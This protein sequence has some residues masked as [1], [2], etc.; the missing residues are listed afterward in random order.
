MRAKVA[1]TAVFCVLSFLAL[2]ANA[3]DSRPIKHFRG[4]GAIANK[5]GYEINK[6][7]V[8]IISGNPNGT[9]LRLAYDMSAVLDSD[10]LRVLPI[11]GAGGGGNIKDVRFLKGIDLG[12]TQSVLLNRYKRTN[13]IGPIDDKLVYIAKLNNEE[14]HVVVRSDSGIESIEQL[15]GK[16]VNFS[17]VGSGSQLSNQEIFSRLNIKVT[18]VNMGQADGFE[19]LKRGEIAATILIAGKPTGSTRT[20]KSSEG[21]KILP[22]AYSKALQDEFLPA[23]LTHED[24]PDLIAPGQRVDTIAVSCVLFAYNWAK[25]TD[26]YQRLVRFVDAFFPRLADFQKKPR[27]PK[28]KEAN[29]AAVLPGWKR[30]DGAEE[31][32]AKNQP[33][34]AATEQRSKIDP[35]LALRG[36]PAA[37]GAL[38]F[39]SEDEERLF[40]EFLEWKKS[41]ERR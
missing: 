20:L 14:M 25:D 39:A 7:T 21:F 23:V 10:N 12:I 35:S 17:D 9:Y 33:K 38:G 11:I 8:G 16:K 26:R 13:E 24:Y 3:Q 41:R 19:A 18:E 29:L 27:H 34:P 30:F 15:A 37:G 4:D 6:D 2:P 28:W 36:A 22:V 5:L 31:W 1:S 32:L 40:E